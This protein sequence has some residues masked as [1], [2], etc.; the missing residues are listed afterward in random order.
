MAGQGAPAT[1][2]DYRN[3]LAHYQQ[4]MNNLKDQ[5]DFLKHLSSSDQI[6][7]KVPNNVAKKAQR[8]DIGARQNLPPAVNN[9]NLPSIGGP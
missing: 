3:M 4:H 8:S 5:Q 9:S 2:L 1:N 6:E 7:F